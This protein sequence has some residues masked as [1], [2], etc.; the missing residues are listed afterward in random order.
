[1][2]ES[3]PEVPRRNDGYAGVCPEFQYC[4]VA[5]DDDIHS[6][7]RCA[8][9]NCRIRRVNP[10]GATAQTRRRRRKFQFREKAGQRLDPIRRHAQLSQKIA[11]QF[12]QYRGANND[13]ML[14]QQGTQQVGTQAASC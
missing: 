10:R 9:E 13:V 3:L 6:G 14:R 4:A 8:F 1:M 5:G 2:L 11:S 12:R 7:A